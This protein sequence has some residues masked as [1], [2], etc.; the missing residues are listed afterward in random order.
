MCDGSLAI[1][2]F[3]A[4]GLPR[5]P[6]SRGLAFFRPVLL[7]PVQKPSPLPLSSAR[8]NGLSSRSGPQPHSCAPRC[9]SW[10]HATINHWS[11]LLGTSPPVSERP[12]GRFRT[13]FFSVQDPQTRRARI[14]RNR[15]R[16][17]TCSFS[18]RM[19]RKGARRS[20]PRPGSRAVT[21]TQKLCLTPEPSVCEH[22][23]TY[24]LF[25]PCSSVAQLVEHPAV[26]RRVVGSSPT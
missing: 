15:R 14:Y 5:E 10:A 2:H 21:Q 1:R 13:P 18:V 3:R 22:E 12:P 19:L 16:P 9:H 7:G 26:N 8:F 6:R 25:L 23:R 17:T 11:P 4:C 20:G 24:P